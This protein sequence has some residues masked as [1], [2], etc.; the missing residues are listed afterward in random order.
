MRNCKPSDLQALEVICGNLHQIGVEIS[1]INGKLNRLR[2]E[3]ENY[4]KQEQEP[5][6]VSTPHGLSSGNE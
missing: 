4:V 3:I 1:V 5:I 6:N 2:K